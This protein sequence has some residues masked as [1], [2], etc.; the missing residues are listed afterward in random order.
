[1]CIETIGVVDI[2][3]NAERERERERE[4]DESVATGF[5]PG[6]LFLTWISNHMPSKVWDKIAYPMDK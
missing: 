5:L 6:P 4:R 1:M 2:M 3:L